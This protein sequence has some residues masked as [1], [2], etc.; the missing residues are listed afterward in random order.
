LACNDIINLLVAQKVNFYGLKT[1]NGYHLYFKN[2]KN[3]N[4]EST[5]GACALGLKPCDYK[6]TG[7]KMTICK[8]GK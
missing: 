4:G 2:D 3:V 8:A 1:T 6:K 7:A 5:G